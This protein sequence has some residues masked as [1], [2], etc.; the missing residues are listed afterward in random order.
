MWLR[1]IEYQESI[2]EKG[3][4][5]YMIVKQ[6]VSRICSRSRKR[7]GLRLKVIG[8]RV[9]MWLVLSIPLLAFYTPNTA[10]AKGVQVHA[11]TIQTTTSEGRKTTT[12]STDAHPTGCNPGQSIESCVQSLTP[13]PAPRIQN[14]LGAKA[15]IFFTTPLEATVGSGAVTT[16]WQITLSIVDAFIVFVLALS[17]LRIMIAGSVFRHAN[18]IEELPGALLALIAAHLSMIF[19]TI[20]LGLNNAL[21]VILLNLANTALGDV[22]LPFNIVPD[23]FNLPNMGDVISAAFNNLPGLMIKVLGLM[24]LAQVIIRMFFINLYIILAPLGIACW[25]LPGKAGQPLT[26]QWFSGFISVVMVQ[27]LQVAAIV[28]AELML[29]TVN[30]ALLPQMANIDKNSLLQILEIAIMW[31]ILRIP[32]LLGTAPMR[33]L[34]EAGQA[35]GQAAGASLAVSAAQI[36]GIAQAAGTLGPLAGLA[37]A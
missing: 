27:F 4:V 10:L 18:A 29:G 34:G 7:G 5:K 6:F 1:I 2:S 26:Q 35:M 20:I 33:T 16:F 12:I 31:F 3:L 17:G 21:S 13:P 36:Q 24:L 23:S 9:L 32:S 11:G 22:T 19:V 15:T 25:A 8:W 30:N 14:P 28:I 37:F